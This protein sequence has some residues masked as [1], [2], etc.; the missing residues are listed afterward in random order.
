MPLGLESVPEPIGIVAAVA[1]QLLRLRQAFQQR[2]RAGV[3]ADLP[4]GHEEAQGAPVCV[5]DGMKL[6]AAFGAP[7]QMAAVPFFTRR[8]EA[9]R[10]ALRY[11]ASIMTVFGSA[12]TAAKPSII[13]VITPA[14]PQRVQR[15]YSVL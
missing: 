15:L 7:D 11:V 13:R 1:D 9:V 4:G 3:V 8:L 10:C 6:H 14:S 5:G 12:P 2:C